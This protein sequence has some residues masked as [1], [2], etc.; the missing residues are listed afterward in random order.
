MS[1]GQDSPS[2]AVIY[3]IILFAISWRPR[4]IG[5]AGKSKPYGKPKL[6]LHKNPDNISQLE[7]ITMRRIY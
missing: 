1:P 5:L 6:L 3:F 7:N 2:Q 4:D